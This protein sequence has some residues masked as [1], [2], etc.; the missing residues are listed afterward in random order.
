MSHFDFAGPQTEF[1][2]LGNIAT[3]YPEGFEFDPLKMKIPEMM[4]QI[5]FCTWIIGRGGRYRE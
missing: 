1:A 4:K 3:L 5:G 2:L